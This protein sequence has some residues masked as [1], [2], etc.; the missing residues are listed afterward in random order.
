MPASEAQILA[1]QANSSRSSGPVSDLG[2]IRSRANSLKHG[3]TGAGIVL[4]EEDVAEVDRLSVEL[5]AQFQ[6]TGGIG[7]LLT[8]QLATVSVRMDRSFR[9]EIASLSERVR[10]VMDEF[11]PP[12]GVDAETAELLRAEAGEIAL[13]DTSKDACLARKYEA[14]DRR[15]FFRL[16]QDLR[17]L[18]KEATRQTK[19]PE[20]APSAPPKPA[21]SAAS[22]AAAEA[23]SSLDKLGSFFQKEMAS[24]PTPARPVKPALKHLELTAKP[25]GLPIS[26]VSEIP[27]AI[28]GRR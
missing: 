23:Q 4:P 22:K 1:N 19:A 11:E 7:A 2:K 15:S 27:F 28:G 21:P 12:E 18:N 8:R 9:Q 16:L 5:G 25:W 17:Q 14:A 3:L 20:A 24:P 26:G 13:F 6:A 10:R